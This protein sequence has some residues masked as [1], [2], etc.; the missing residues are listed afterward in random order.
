[1]KLYDWMVSEM[2]I[3]CII[4]LWFSLYKEGVYGKAGIFSCRIE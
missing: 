1:M 3:Y 4:E 2:N